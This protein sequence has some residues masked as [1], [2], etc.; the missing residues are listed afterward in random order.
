MNPEIADQDERSSLV[1]TQ[2]KEAFVF[3]KPITTRG[4][5][6]L[7]IM[8]IIEEDQC[9]KDINRGINRFA[10]DED[11]VLKVVKCDADLDK[12]RYLMPDVK[13]QDKDNSKY[14]LIRVLFML[15]RRDSSQS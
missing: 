13:P 11:K 14:R 3:L 7:E 1:K 5:V 15:D 9:I 2:P 6:D 4:E 8:D 12:C 10:H